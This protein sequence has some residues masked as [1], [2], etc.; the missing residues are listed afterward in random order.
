M[1]LIT[2][3]PRAEG[4]FVQ[5]DWASVAAAYDAVHITLRAITA[6]QGFSFATAHGPTVAP[7]W[8]AGSNLWLSWC[9]SAAELIEVTGPATPSTRRPPLAISP[10]RVARH[11]LSLPGFQ[12]APPPPAPRSPH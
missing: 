2:T 7:Y 10:A 1:H 8:D 4:G 5:P 12:R 3:H 9:F 11:P 6:A